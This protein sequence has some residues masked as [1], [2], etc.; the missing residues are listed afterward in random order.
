[1]FKRFL[2][3]TLILLFIM[4]VL[5]QD[6][7]N[8]PDAAI[9]AALTAAEAQVGS[10]AGSFTF[11]F[12]GESNDSSLGCALVQGEELPFTLEVVLVNAIYPD[13]TYTVYSSI[14]GQVVILC[15][16]QFGEEVLAGQID[17]E[18]ICNATPVSALPAYEAPNLDLDGVF[19]AGVEEYPVYGVSSDAGWY[20][21]ASEFGLGWV[22][23]TSVTVSGD[24]SNVPV[25]AVTNLDAE[26]VCFITAQGG[27]TNVRATPEG[28]L[29]GRIYENEAYQITAR[30][31]SA[32]WFF[33]QP[34]GWV[35]NTVVFQL[36]DCTNIPVNDNAVG[37]GFENAE[38]LPIDTNP[39][40]VLENL[41]CPADFAG[42][43]PTRISVGDG[44]A[45]VEAGGIPNT[46]RAFPS[47]D[48]AEGPR[49]GTIQP[50]RVIDRVIAG[51][52]CNQGF[53]WWLVEIDGVVGWTAESN[54]SSNDYFLEPTGDAPVAS[55]SSDDIE[56]GI[57][58]VEEI[59][60]NSNGSRLFAHADEQGFGD[61]TVGAVIVFDAATGDSIA[62][63]EE[64]AGVVDI[65]YAVG[66]DDV[67]IAAGNGTIT[68]YNSQSFEQT[69]QITGAFSIAEQTRVEIM[70]DSSFIIVAS[71]TDD[72]CTASEITVFDT[73]GAEL[74]ASTLESPVID[75]AISDDGS[76]LAVITPAGVSFHAP[77]TLAI[78][79]TWVNSDGF[80]LS[81]IAINQDGTSALIAGCNNADCTE[82]RIGLINTADGSLLGIVPSHTV[83]ATNITFNNDDTRFVTVAETGEIIERSATTGE[84]TQRF[85]VDTVT[86][87]SVAYTPDGSALAIGTSDGR[88]QFLPL[89]N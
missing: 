67:L 46:L 70:P 12:L 50:Q 16:A 32:T 21:I 74:T 43:M 66:T 68:L 8:T 11:Q 73:T 63:V 84:E 85:V 38:S 72:T 78:S 36:G 54:Q 33:I 59:I 69:A 55:T 31:T 45:Q 71:C 42:Y 65:D 87:V 18:T 28:E 27:F 53:V 86:V 25:T 7:A 48:D 10:R 51:P 29:T 89:M 15:D 26:G 9:N 19:T 76:T 22:E 17:S 20:Q 52:A 62:R 77:D 6:D 34:A 83:E 41:P 75:M 81:S 3:L 88:V 13:A 5:A 24:C 79:S 80:S 35:S 60:Y 49:I 37:I 14:S 82:G 56:V 47:V 44:T 57:N 64:P 39:N 58:P 23:A 2:V 61:G 40:V 4:P 30:N 1:M